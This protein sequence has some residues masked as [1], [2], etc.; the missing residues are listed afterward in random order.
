MQAK[1][2]HRTLLLAGVL[3]LVFA[4]AATPALAQT[5]ASIIGLDA[6]G[7][8]IT[9]KQGEEVRFAVSVANLDG[10]LTYLWD[11]GDG[12]TSTD[13]EPV[14]V[15]REAGD[16]TATVRMASSYQAY[17]ENITVARN[18]PPAEMVAGRKV[19]VLQFDEYNPKESV[20]V[21]VYS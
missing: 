16:Y 21:A 4:L 12:T 5:S 7:N 9:A 17:L 8:Q 18:L 11:F 3:T 15:Y 2:V 13:A 20:V 10:Q 6:D 1:N 19:A 14:H